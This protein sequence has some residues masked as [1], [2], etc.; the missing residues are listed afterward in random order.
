M[1]IPVHYKV[2]GE[3]AELSG[4]VIPLLSTILI[5]T[6][7]GVIPFLFFKK[8]RQWKTPIY[9]LLIISGWQYGGILAGN[10]YLNF[11]EMKI[12]NS[13]IFAFGILFLYLTVF[14]S[15]PIIVFQWIK[16]NKWKHLFWLLPLVFLYIGLK[17]NAQMHPIPAFN[18][19]LKPHY[20][21]N[22]GMSGQPF[23]LFA[24]GDSQKVELE[25]GYSQQQDSQNDDGINFLKQFKS[26]LPEN[27]IIDPKSLR[28]LIGSIYMKTNELPT[29]DIGSEY[30]YTIKDLKL[31]SQYGTNTNIL[32]TLDYISQKNPQDILEEYET[33]LVGLFALENISK[34]E[35]N[36]FLTTY[37]FF[38]G[39]HLGGISV[40]FKKEFKPDYSQI[41][42]ES[43]KVIELGGTV[44]NQ[45]KIL[46][47]KL[48]SCVYFGIN[49][50]IIDHL[51]KNK[52]QE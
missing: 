42:I 5:F 29:K 51:S 47:N 41:E 2:L 48:K 22:S 40:F 46:S 36:K 28:G 26:N 24:K 45:N 16:N 25:E 1:K 8:T 20:G 6:A 44:Y 49:L 37:L 13:R 43:Q 23:L 9:I 39:K 52:T 18:S 14:V 27:S 17:I 4:F 34:I 7:V 11:L 21:Y 38:V 30:N 50:D 31:C 12:P 10:F 32:S 19:T 35:N 3:M 15:V 33:A